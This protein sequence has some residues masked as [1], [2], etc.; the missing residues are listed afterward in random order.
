M[1]QV[2]TND[3]IEKAKKELLS[4]IESEYDELVNLTQSPIEKLFLLSFL[5]ICDYCYFDQFCYDALGNLIMAKTK[6]YAEDVYIIPQN[7]IGNYRVDFLFVINEKKSFIVECDGHD[8]HEKT[9]EQVAN[10]KSRDREFIKNNYVVVRFS[11]SEIYNK[12]SKCVGELEEMFINY[13][14]NK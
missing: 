12:P 6:L 7:E 4:S 5:S 9:K 1:T 11:G 3:K 13:W 14:K 2:D 10:D 8:F